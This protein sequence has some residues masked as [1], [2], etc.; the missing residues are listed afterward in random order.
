MFCYRDYQL[1]TR[2]N[3]QNE[4]STSNTLLSPHDSDSPAAR[5]HGLP[6]IHKSNMP[7]HPIVSAC[8]T[9]THITAKF[10]TKIIP[11]TMARVHILLKIVQISSKK[12]SIFN[13]S[14]RRILSLICCQCSLHQH[15]GTCCTTSY[16]LQKFLPAP[17][18]TN[19]CMIPR[20]KFISSGIHYH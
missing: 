4:K 10:T 5:F 3:Q 15:T 2:F 6:L 12:L 1:T 13:K 7:M 19:V 11:N 9:T 8:G 18:F 14:R 17:I 16:Q 20:E